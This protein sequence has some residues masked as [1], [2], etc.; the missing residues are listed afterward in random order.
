MNLNCITN[1]EQLLKAK[2]TNKIR[3]LKIQKPF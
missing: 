3:E 1:N 2:V